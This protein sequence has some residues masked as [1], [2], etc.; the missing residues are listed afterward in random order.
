MIPGC[1]SVKGFWNLNK[2]VGFNRMS[3]ISLVT[4]MISVEYYIICTILSVGP[5]VPIVLS[6]DLCPPWSEASA[7]DRNEIETVT[8]SQRKYLQPIKVPHTDVWT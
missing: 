5:G 2:L 6:P 7:T 8:A 3:M 4:D 1:Q